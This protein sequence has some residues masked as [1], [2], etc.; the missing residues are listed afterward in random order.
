MSPSLIEFLEHIQK[1]LTFLVT[2]SRTIT[3]DKFLEDDLINRAYL[4]SLEIIGE[5]SKK[6]PDEIRY[7]YKEVDWRGMTGLRDVLIHE[8]FQV[9]YEL[10][11]E[12]IQNNIPLAK[13]WLDFIIMEEK[14]Q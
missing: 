6:V 7:K 3:F 13:E 8:Y 9:D 5:A 10:V 1:E 2:H 11:W 12:V 4:R 14:R